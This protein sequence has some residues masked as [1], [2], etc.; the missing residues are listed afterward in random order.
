MEQLD[1]DFGIGYAVRR[2]LGIA[3]ERIRQDEFGEFFE[4][5]ST[6]RDSTP[7]G[8][9]ARLRKPAECLHGVYTRYEATKNT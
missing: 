6:N 1:K 2:Q 9:T 3:T 7:L 8:G 4:W 5:N